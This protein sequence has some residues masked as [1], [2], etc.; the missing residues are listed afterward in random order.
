MHSTVELVKLF[1]VHRILF[2]KCN[3]KNYIYS[4]TQSIICKKP[5]SNYI[6]CLVK[7]NFFH[8]HIYI[9]YIIT[10]TKTHN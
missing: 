5:F 4:Y 8:T 6:N 1:I 9:I 3:Q 7:T 10:F 2:D